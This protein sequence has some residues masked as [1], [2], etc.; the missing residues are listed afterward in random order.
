MAQASRDENFVTTL[1]A[2]S[3]VDGVTP[4]TLYANPTTHRLLV[5]LAGGGSGTV[6]TVAVATANGF[7]GTSDGNAAAPTITLT[8]S[9]TGILKGNGTAISA[10]TVGSGLSYDG[11][12]LSA[13]G[14]AGTPGGSNTQ[15]QYN[16]AG[17]F[18]GITGATSDGTTLTLVSPIL[19][20]PTSVTLT[21]ATGL[22]LTTG[23]TGNLPVTNLNSGTSASAS[24]YWRGD[25]TWA[26]PA[27]GGGD[28][29]FNNEYIDQSGGTSDTYGVLAGTINGSNALFTVSE[30]VYATGTLT[31]Y[32]NGQLQT[33]GSSE[34]WVETTPASGTFTFAVPPPTGSLITAVYQTQALSSDTVLV[35]GSLIT[36]LDATAHRLFYSDGSG[37]VTE[38]AF[39][40]SGQYLKALG[41][42][43]APTWDTPTGSGS[44]SVN[45]E[46]AGSATLTTAELSDGAGSILNIVESN[47]ASQ[48][49]TLPA[50]DTAD[51]GKFYQI[52]N[53]GTNK[54]TITSA[55]TLNGDSVVLGKEAGCIAYVSANG[56]YTL[57]GTGVENKALEFAVTEWTTNLSTG[58]GKYYFAVPAEYDGWEVVA[59]PYARVIT[60]GTTGTTDIQ[61]HNVTDTVDILS[62][63]ITIDST[64]TGS[65]TAVTPPVINS[66]NKNLAAFDLLRIDIDAVSTTPPQGLLVVINIEPL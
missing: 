17:A 34:D 4:V 57:V 19:G 41:T 60:A 37:N 64:E 32:L 6:Q 26:T 15:V 38:L 7:A 18:G 33:Q 2:V 44:Q 52:Y 58:D 20:T 5:D 23:V 63:K 12:T 29:Y 14:G 39:G 10:I 24:T 28:N 16:N 43:T 30:A 61:I 22:P 21:N 27:G 66:S 50:A 1:L 56:F 46:A 13:T 59:T 47:A 49:I 3:S 40:T 55:S 9:V 65:N 45:T 36:Q 11:T 42:T 51:I 48:T 35:E 54:M 8:T 53:K 62:T 31:V 25:G